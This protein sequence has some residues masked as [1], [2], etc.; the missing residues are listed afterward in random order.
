MWSFGVILYVLLSGYLPFN[1]YTNEV[2][3]SKIMKGKYQLHSDPWKNVSVTARD[4]IRGLLT[5]D[6]HKRLTVDQALGHAWINQDARELL[7]KSL[8]ENI[9]E[10]R[11]FQVRKR[12]RKAVHTVLALLKFCG[13]AGFRIELDRTPLDE[14]TD[15]LAAT[16]LQNNNAGVIRGAPM[17]TRSSVMQSITLPAP[18]S[19]AVHPAA[20]AGTAAATGSRPPTNTSNH[21]NNACTLPSIGNYFYFSSDIVKEGE[22]FSIHH[23]FHYETKEEVLLKV[24]DCSRLSQQDNT[25]IGYEY[26]LVKEQLAGSPNIIRYENAINDSHKKQICIVMESLYGEELFERILQRQFYSEMKARQLAETM[27]KT[28]KFMHDKNVIHR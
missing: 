27:L 16:N 8:N 14:M 26:Y 22:N 2:I 28:I 6:P 4:L 7:L 18:P 13:L 5:L 24:Y 19:P 17:Q 15:A 10:I 23:G 9:R 12:F 3:Y 21:S 20:T 11:K 25:R 1:G